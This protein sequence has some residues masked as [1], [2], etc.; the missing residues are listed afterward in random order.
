MII[1]DQAK[2]YIN[3]MMEENGE[4]NLRFTFEGAGC[5]GPNF[6]VTLSNRQEGDKEDIINGVK[7]SI[8]ERVF[9][10]V[11]DIILDFEG[12]GEEGGLVLKGNNSCC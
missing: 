10:A 4:S 3:K 6:G 5:C 8:D 9:N 2:V 7:V 1:T 12:E 11:Q